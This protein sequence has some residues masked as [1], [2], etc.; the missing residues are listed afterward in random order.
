MALAD[1]LVTI[2]GLP[3]HPLL[4]H[5]VVVLLPLAAASAA[6]LAVVP[7]WRQRYAWLLL[8]VTLVAVGSVPLAQW[9]GEQLYAKM[10]ALGNPLIQRHADLGNDLLPFA[11][12]FGVVVV[13]LLVSGRLADRE[14]AAAADDPAVPKTWRRIAVVVAVLVVAAGAAATIQTVRIGHSGS[15][16]VYDFVRTI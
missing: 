13:A 11:L 16:A 14:R 6:A 3:A 1:D 7:R 12:G 5:A 8:G 4:V 15:T 2:F 10:A 9:A